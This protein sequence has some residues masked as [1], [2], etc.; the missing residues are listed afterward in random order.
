M[1][2]SEVAKSRRPAARHRAADPVHARARRLRRQRRQAVRADAARADAGVGL[3]ALPTRSSS[4]LQPVIDRLSGEAQE[5]CSMAILDGDDV[6]FI[7]RASPTRIFSAG[8]RYRLSPAGVLHLGRP[9]AAGAAVRRRTGR[10][11][12][13]KMDRAALTPLTVTDK[14]LLLKTIIA[15]RAQGYSLVDREAEPRLPLDRGADPP[16][17]R[18]NRRRHQHRR[19]CRPDLAQVTRSYLFANVE[20]ATRPEADALTRSGA[21]A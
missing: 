11:R 6:V 7:A 17:R 21:R 10:K 3:S 12:S 15:D 13:T 5:V 19:A 18:R 20:R 1:T 14:K 16:L 2:L 4:V 9:R 8:H